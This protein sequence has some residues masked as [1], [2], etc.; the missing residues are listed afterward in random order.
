[1][2]LILMLIVEVCISCLTKNII[3][4]NIMELVLLIVNIFLVGIYLSTK[5]NNKKLLIILYF[6]YLI[7]ILFMFYDLYRAPLPFSGADTWSFHNTGIKISEALPNSM[8]DTPYGLYAQF[9]GIIYYLFGGSVKMFVQ[10]INI[11]L[12][13]ASTMKII[14]VLNLYKV[15]EKYINLSIFLY[16]FIMPVSLFQ[17]TILLREMMIVY[18]MTQSIY[19][20]LKY[21]KNNIKIYI[22]YAY[23]FL[24]IASAFHS[25]LIIVVLPYTYILCLYDFRYS[26]FIV[27]HKSMILL[28]ITIGVIIA[29]FNV[30]GEYFVHLKGIEDIQSIIDKVNPSEHA[31]SAGSA[32]L[33]DLYVVSGLGL[34]LFTPLKVLYFLFS[35]MPW[36]IRGGMDIVTFLLDSML[37]VI[38]MYSYGNMKK[39]K[40][41]IPIEIYNIVN[42]LYTIYLIM[43]IPYAWGTVAA[44]TAIRH[45]FKGFFIILIAY[46]IYK[47]YLDKYNKENE[48]VRS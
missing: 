7:R 15:D 26:K 20:L 34:I 30:F 18:F 22:L 16:V 38:A 43:V 6:G 3:P 19:S 47:N 24:F 14:E 32:Y 36:Q 28:I 46:T 1:M 37:Y 25:G 39:K 13:I 9:V 35:P 23:I 40:H 5:I 44:G 4:Y 27:T 2:D 31:K 10:H 42:I 21:L 8:L 29:G 41:K 48:L 17:S 12:F 11:L 33:K 45:R